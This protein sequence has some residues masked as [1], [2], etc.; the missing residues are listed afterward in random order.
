M[1]MK[2]GCLFTSIARGE[3]R[4]KFGINLETKEPEKSWNSIRFANASIKK[5]HEVKRERCI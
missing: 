2:L 3:F 5:G 1:I 4:M